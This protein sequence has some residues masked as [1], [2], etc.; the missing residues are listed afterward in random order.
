MVLPVGQGYLEVQ[1][2][3]WIKTACGQIAVAICGTRNLALQTI[4]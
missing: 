4:Q 2:G 1:C 3:R